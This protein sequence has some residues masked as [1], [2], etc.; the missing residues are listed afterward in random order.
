LFVLVPIDGKHALEGASVLITWR[1]RSY[2]RNAALI[3]K[4]HE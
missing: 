4:K 2:E 3:V 1:L